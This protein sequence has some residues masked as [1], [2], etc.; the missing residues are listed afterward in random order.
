M[1]IFLVHYFI[2]KCARAYVERQNMG[3][4]DASLGE[5]TSGGLSEDAFQ[6][7]GTVIRTGVDVLYLINTM[8]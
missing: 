2:E 1:L 6:V 3:R 8:F 4:F 7:L 5:E